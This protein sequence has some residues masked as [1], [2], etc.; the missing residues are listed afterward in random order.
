[1]HAHRLFKYDHPL[2]CRSSQHVS[3]HPPLIPRQPVPELSVETLG[4]S[5]WKMSEQSPETF[6][7]VVLFRGLHCPICASYLSDLQRKLG[8]FAKQGVNVIAISSDSKQ[9]AKKS[10]EDW[11]LDKLTLGYGLDLNTARRWGLFISMGR[12]PTSSGI[13]ETRLFSEPG[14]RL[15]P[16]DGTLYLGSV[17]T[18]PFSRPGFAEILNGVKSALE[19]D[20]PAH[21]QV[22][23]H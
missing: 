17:Q 9:R 4:G 22:I 18:M 20:H 16:S 14:L 15:I 11:G 12:G 21:G 3:I 19:K 1:M 2:I 7:L 5:T 6:T 23:D 13:E 8:D 10:V